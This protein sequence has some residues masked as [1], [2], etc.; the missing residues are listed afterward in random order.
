MRQRRLTR[1]Q[2]KQ[3]RLRRK[4]F[5]QGGGAIKPLLEAA[6]APAI[7]NQGQVDFNVR[8]QP[9]IKAREDGPTFTTYQTAHEPYPVWSAPT[10]PTVYTIICWD[11]DAPKKSF[12]HWM[13]V[14]CTTADNSDG[15]VIASWSPPSPPPGTGEH[16]YILGLF[17]HENK[18]TIP[19]I[20][21]RTGFNPTAFATQHGLT[22]VAYRGFR[23]K[24]ADAVAPPQ[25]NPKAASSA[26]AIP[27]IQN[28]L[29]PAPVALAMV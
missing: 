11:P 14:N 22:P 24:A 7:T 29:P 12:L 28:V 17:K 25:T 3:K 19:E 15:K 4:T 23:V 16:R 6:D 18:I 21:D 5:R 10:A 9:S 2:K 8:F 13:I 27:P 26:T 1:R 20:T